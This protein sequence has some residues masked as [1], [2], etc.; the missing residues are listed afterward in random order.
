MNLSEI[1]QI[2][3]QES[4]REKRIIIRNGIL[5]LMLVMILGFLIIQFALPFI[6]QY[7]KNA[8]SEVNNNKSFGTY[9]KI[10]FVVIA[11]LSIYYQLIKLL[12]VFN[13]QKNINKAF[14]LIKSGKKCNIINETTIYLTI[15][16]L[17]RIKLKLDPITFLEV[18]I[19]KN[20]F[21]LPINK[22]L[23]PDI[24]RGLSNAN[25]THYQSIMSELYNKNEIEKSSEIIT[26][27]L[28]PL[29][30]FK[31]FA[32]KEFSQELSSMEKNRSKGKSMLYAQSLVIFIFLSSM[33]Y[34]FSTNKIQIT[35]SQDIFILTGYVVAFSVLIGLVSYIY[36]KKNM[37]GTIDFTQFKNIIFNR[38]VQYINPSFEYI[39]K[40]HI[41]LTEF[42]DSGLFKTKNYT[43]NGADQIIGK[44]NGVPFQSCNLAVTFRPNFRDEKQA[45]DTIFYGNYF[46]ARFPKKFEGS[47]LIYSKKD[48]LSDIKDNEIGSYLNISDKKIRLEDPDFQKQFEVYCHNQIVARYVLTPSFIELIKKI[49]IQNKG[50]IYISISQ[51]NIVIATNKRNAS[52]YGNTTYKI[53]S[54]KIDLELLNNIYQELIGQLQMID[55]LKLLT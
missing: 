38:L 51:N 41:G 8:I 44:Y 55:T 53:F 17:Y 30:E 23:S 12:P 13:R 9:F 10:I 21:Q 4:L 29:S 18:T 11:L 49:N 3:L 14:S 22:M 20:N 24:K 42:L 48:F 16:P 2:I 32:E 45:D 7:I 37:A 40:S 43:I 5:V 6:T 33:I 27:K 25:S 1:K 46:V 36:A 54:T 31:Q 15:I 39:E 47:V 28:K 19:E 52:M 35:R 26:T 50:N 34:F